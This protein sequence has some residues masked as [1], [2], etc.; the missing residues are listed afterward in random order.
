IDLLDFLFCFSDILIKLAAAREKYGR[1]I[2]VF[3]TPLAASS[4]PA[5]A[6]SSDDVADDFYE[7]T[8]E[9]YYRLMASKKE[10]KYL[11]TKKIRDAEDDARRAKASRVTMR[12]RFPDNHTVEA[13][14]HSS[15]TIQSL[16]DLVS[17]VIARPEVPFHLYTAPPKKR[18]ND[19]SQDLYSAG[20]VPGAI[21]YFA[22]N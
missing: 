17:Q 4:T 12:V 15:E 2:R 10:D 19:L 22:T 9:D 13:S 14:F 20:F 11:K 7:F 1:D 18:M 5:N 6:S 21:V 8:A 16:V 3:E